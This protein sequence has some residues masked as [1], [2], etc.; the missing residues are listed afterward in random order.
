MRNRAIALVA[1]SAA[2]ALALAG[3]GDSVKAG[4]ENAATNPA[5]GIWVSPTVGA[6]NISG[7]V[8][9]PVPANSPPP[10][11]P[12]AI[13]PPGQTAEVA[14]IE[15][16]VSGGCWQDAGLG[17]RYGAY[18]QNFWFQGDCADTTAQV[19]VELYP[20]PA[21]ATTS[22]HHPTPTALLDRYQDGAILVD[23]Y[24]NAPSYV[25]TELGAI[26]GLVPVPGYG[27]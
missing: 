10:S 14:K 13:V 18:N 25:L 20:T 21:A 23:V 26:K 2:L 24:A 22:S 11:T 1:G 17:D 27:G 5:S 15:L 16:V 8:G 19:A 6:D 3:C 12:P 4:G 7:H 9:P